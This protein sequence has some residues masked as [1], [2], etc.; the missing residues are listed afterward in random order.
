M[1]FTRE[2]N[3]GEDVSISKYGENDFII[4]KYVGP[5]ADGEN[6]RSGS[7]QNS[8]NWIVY[9]L[10]DVMLMKAEA[11]SQ[12]GRFQEALDIINEI[13]VRADVPAISFP[14]RSLPM[15]MPSWRNGPLSWHLRARGGLT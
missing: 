2:L 7:E 9:R 15:K 10:A 5:G 12:L 13:R 4:W 1:E 11:L 3:R 8:A 14:T 6:T